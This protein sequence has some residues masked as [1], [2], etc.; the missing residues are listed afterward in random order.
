MSYRFG[1][2]K[3]IEVAVP[4]GWDYRMIT[5]PCGS[6]SYTGGVNQCDCCADKYGTPPP[7]REDEGDLEYDTRIT[8]DED[9]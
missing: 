8:N 2:G 9:Y 4:R 3:K 6:T 5:V 1:C 7:P